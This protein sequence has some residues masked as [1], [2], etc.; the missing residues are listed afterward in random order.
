MADN[1]WIDKLRRNMEGFRQDP[2]EGLWEGVQAGLER[3]RTAVFPWWWVLAGAAAAVAAVLVLVRP[4]G[5][6]QQDVPVVAKVTAES[7]GTS[8]PA[9]TATVISAPELPA[10]LPLVRK[11]VATAVPVTTEVTESELVPVSD[12]IPAAD[13]VPSADSDSEADSIPSSDDHKDVPE[14]IHTVPL[15]QFPAERPLLA[16]ASRSRATLSIV[17]SG[18]PGSGYSGSITEYGMPPGMRM[19]SS[20]SLSSV[21]SRNRSTLTNSWYRVNFRF[22]LMA[23]IPL[24]RRW[25]VESGVQ[26]S[27]LTGGVTSTSGSMSAET[28]SNLYYL[29]IPVHAVFMPWEGRH[30][31]VYVSAGPMAELG[32]RMS[33]STRESIG[34][35]VNTVLSGIEGQAPSA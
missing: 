5:T 24:T 34:N 14:E 11:A 8:E 4:G 33:G 30:L 17:A 28:S 12:S 9:D 23:N 2:P 31:G 22:G 18:I 29:G 19:A 3:R 7:P 26:I 16:S 21:L 15:K 25:S 6:L 13:S 27:H 10:E 32:V 1:K 35:V 20:R